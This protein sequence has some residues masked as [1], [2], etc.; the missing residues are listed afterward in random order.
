MGYEYRCRYI[1]HHIRATLGELG[2][3]PNPSTDGGHY[4]FVST[5]VC[6]CIY[7]GITLGIS[8]KYNHRVLYK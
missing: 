5:L 8:N 4:F 6:M 7:V 1:S 2:G 3:G